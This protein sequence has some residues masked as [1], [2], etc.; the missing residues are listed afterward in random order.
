MVFLSC[1]LFKIHPK[2]YADVLKVLEKPNSYY[3]YDETDGE[4]LYLF[5]NSV[6][7]SEYGKFIDVFY[8]VMITIKAM[9]PGNML[10]SVKRVRQTEGPVSLHLFEEEPLS[11]V[12]GVFSNFFIANR[13]RSILT[14]TIR[15][16]I[17]KVVSPITEITFLLQEKEEEIRKIPDFTNVSEVRV[18][19]A[20]DLYIEELWL[21]GSYLDDS[22]EYKKFV[23]DPA[24]AGKM[25]FLALSYKDKVYYLID[26]G[27]VFT[28]QASD[29]KWDIKDIYQIVKKLLEA[30]AVRFS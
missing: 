6:K 10:M 3:I 21:K 15:K 2:H 4:H 11:N 23:T 20:K 5:I 28:R 7:N 17:D 19:E 29:I 22:E 12:I 26:D 13:I 14:K 25:K 1:K 18:E 24:F 27:R 16:I 8:D 9:D 30:G